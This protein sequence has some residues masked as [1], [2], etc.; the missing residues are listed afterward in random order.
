[1][2]K[3]SIF[4]SDEVFSVYTKSKHKYQTKSD[5]KSVKKIDRF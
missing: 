5:L 1:M 4:A 3:P 2:P